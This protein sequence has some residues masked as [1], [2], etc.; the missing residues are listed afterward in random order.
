MG[1]LAISS[2]TKWTCINVEC[3]ATN[4]VG[5][6][7]NCKSPTLVTIYESLPD[8]NYIYHDHYSLVCPRCGEKY[9]DLR[10][11]K[12]RKITPVEKSGLPFDRSSCFIATAAYGSP[13]E[14]EVNLLRHYR[15]AYL[16]QTISGRLIVR[17]YE[18]IA[19]PIARWI[20]PRPYA[21]RFVR[22]VVMPPL[23]WI[24]RRR[25]R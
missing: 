10:C 20:A 25:D 8:G 3:G 18:F 13:N 2:T 9:W 16:R 7:S 17:L 21:R 24:A 1:R 5:P 11:P 19:P 14:Y 6:C 15:D 22:Q 12:C 23:L 4:E